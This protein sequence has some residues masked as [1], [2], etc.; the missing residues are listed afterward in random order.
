MFLNKSYHEIFNEP[1]AKSLLV[2]ITNKRKY[3]KKLLIDNLK[4]HL[5]GSK[6]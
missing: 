2:G 5:I 1:I 6:Y 3:A 4:L